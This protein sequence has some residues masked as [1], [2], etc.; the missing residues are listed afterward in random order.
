MRGRDCLAAGAVRPRR[1]AEFLARAWTWGRGAVLAAIAAALVTMS[2]AGTALAQAPTTTTVS[3]SLNPSNFGQQVTFTA[4]VTASGS[5]VTTG[6][7]SF[8]DGATVVA[9]IALDPSGQATFT[10]STLAAGS[11]NITATY[12]GTINFL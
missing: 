2:F 3:S 8:N 6:T 11:H 7:V 12:N 1:T 5:P 4:T 9:M 10:T